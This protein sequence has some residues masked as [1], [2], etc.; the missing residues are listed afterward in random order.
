MS[1][2]P[3]LWDVFNTCIS[4]VLLEYRWQTTK[5]SM[6][7]MAF[8]SWSL[9]PCCNTGITTYI[10]GLRTGWQDENKSSSSFRCFAHAPDPWCHWALTVCQT[11]KAPNCLSYILEKLA[12][13][14]IPITQL[15]LG[16]KWQK[17]TSDLLQKSWHNQLL[18][19][20]RASHST[21]PSA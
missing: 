1:I 5:K 19:A 2:P 8:Q 21:V 14:H 6:R 9:Q 20:R 16:T 4:R 12:F 7:S 18:Q 17:C 15:M 3:C 10:T 13:L 11:S